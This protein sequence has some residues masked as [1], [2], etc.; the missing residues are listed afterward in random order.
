MPEV[1]VIIPVYNNEKFV[2]KCIRSVM[3]QSFQD[4]E[5]LVVNDGSTDRSNEILKRLVAEDSRIIYFSQENRGVALA[6]NR[7]LDMASG[8]Y[9]TFVDGET[10]LVGFIPQPSRRTQKCLSVVLPVW[11]WKEMFS[12][13]LYPVSTSVMKGKNGHFGYLRSG[14]TFTGA[15]YGKNI[16][17]ASAPRRGG[18]TCQ[19]PCFLALYVIK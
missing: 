17:P 18:K 19:F 13:V 10:I 6:R 4:L 14:P 2:E 9:L 16:I 12:V 8:K 11:M 5:I 7:A 15:V 3:E 1:S